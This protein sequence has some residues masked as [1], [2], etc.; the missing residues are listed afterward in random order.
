MLK[1]G[2]LSLVESNLVMAAWSVALNAV[3][4]LLLLL[5]PALGLGWAPLPPISSI[6]RAAAF[7]VVIDAVNS[8]V[9]SAL[10]KRSGNLIKIYAFALSTLLTAAIS[11]VLFAYRLPPFFW[12]A[13]ALV[14]LSVA[15]FNAAAQQVWPGRQLQREKRD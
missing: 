10:I 13:A 12:T 1:A 8:L 15:V 4:L 14:V 2:Q 5:A 6:D 3:G 7:A 9:L 11:V